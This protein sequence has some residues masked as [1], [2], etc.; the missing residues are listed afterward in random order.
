LTP[1]T[2]PEMLL[3]SRCSF[4]SIFSQ[5][6]CPKSRKIYFFVHD[7]NVKTL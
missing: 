7:K 5:Q 2:D 6:K 4:S 1:T 3:A